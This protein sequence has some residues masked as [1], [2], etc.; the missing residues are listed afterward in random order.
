MI[1]ITLTTEAREELQALRR[2][3]ALSPGERDRVEMLFLSEEGWSPPRIAAHLGY[4]PKTVR[5]VLGGF[6]EDGTRSLRRR[7]PGPAPNPER[8][9]RITRTLDSLLGQERTWTAAQLAEALGASGFPL[10]TRQTRKYLRAMGAR[11]RR[12]VRT[13][14]HKQDEQ[15]V[16]RARAQLSALKKRPL[17]G[18]WS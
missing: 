6:T 13:L 5:L 16:R 18:D 4:H 14:S 7:P 8:K 17:M 11:W 1:R 12:T 9:E 2:D 10:S 15:K 3:P